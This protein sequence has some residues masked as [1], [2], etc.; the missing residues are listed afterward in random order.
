[1]VLF[2]GE[3]LH[4]TCGRESHS[5]C[6][7]SYGHPLMMVAAALA[8]APIGTAWELHICQRYE[9][10]NPKIMPSSCERKAMQSQQGRCWHEVYQWC[11]SWRRSV[12]LLLSG[13]T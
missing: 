3:E 10:V 12:V 11:C 8:T 4:H 6:E 5:G 13:G 1:M 9:A 2:P 7:D